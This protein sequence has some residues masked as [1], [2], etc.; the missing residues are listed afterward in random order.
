M[1]DVC[2]SNQLLASCWLPLGKKT[3]IQSSS[4]NKS[5][6]SSRGICLYYL[7]TL[8]IALCRVC[9]S[10]IS[11]WCD[12]ELS[13]CC[14]CLCMF[15]LL[16]QWKHSHFFRQDDK[17]FFFSFNLTAIRIFEHHCPSLDSTLTFSKWGGARQHSAPLNSPSAGVWPITTEWSQQEEHM[18]KAGDTVHRPISWDAG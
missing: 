6:A 5:K 9:T 16:R 13:D 2:R 3:S 18:D 17:L 4:L 12:T 10:F 15:L 11:Y 7:V 8:L 14:R 1:L